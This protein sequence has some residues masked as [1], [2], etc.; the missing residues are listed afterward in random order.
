MYNLLNNDDLIFSL[1]MVVLGLFTFWVAYNIMEY[2]DAREKR[3]EPQMDI[4]IYS[5][6]GPTMEELIKEREGKLDTMI[7]NAKDTPQIPKRKRGRPRKNPI[8]DGVST[9]P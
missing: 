5:Y 1:I 8:K 2:L 4:E 7:D 9:R 3:T 6:M